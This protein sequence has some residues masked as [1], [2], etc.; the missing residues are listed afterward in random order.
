MLSQLKVYISYAINSLSESGLPGPE[1][2]YCRQLL[3]S[4]G[5]QIHDIHSHSTLVRIYVPAFHSKDPN[6]ESDDEFRVHRIAY[7]NQVTLPPYVRRRERQS[8]HRVR[9]TD[10][11]RIRVPKLSGRVI[12]SLFASHYK[13][14]P[15][16]CLE[17]ARE[18]LNG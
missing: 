12:K 5:S 11:P 18:K 15:L 10:H 4:C 6:F 13:L 17:E 16:T 9:F 2:S 14:N 3:N 1:Y 8:V 7:H